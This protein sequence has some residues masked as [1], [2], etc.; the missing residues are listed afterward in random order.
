MIDMKYRAT[1]PTEPDGPVW[2]VEGDRLDDGLWHP[3]YDPETWRAL[4]A[5]S[6]ELTDENDNYPR[7][8]ELSLVTTIDDLRY[9]VTPLQGEPNRLLVVLPPEDAGDVFSADVVQSGTPLVA[10]PKQYADLDGNAKD[11]LYNNQELQPKAAKELLGDY[12]SE[13]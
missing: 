9:V 3:S 2:D 5:F 4:M 1:F 7:P 13:D 6:D 11:W 12:E 10:V 8:G